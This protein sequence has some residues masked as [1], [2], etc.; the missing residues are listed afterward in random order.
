MKAFIFDPLWDDLISN[1]LLSKLKN[2]GIEITVTTEIAP[3]K[4]CKALFEGKENRILCIN[5]DYVNWKLPSED[6]QNIPN[7]K[8]ILGA[9]TSSSWIDSSYA[10]SKQIPICNIRNFSTEA[11]AE[12]SITMMFNVARQI[13]RLIKDGFPLDY[14]KDFMKYRGLELHHKTVG[15]IGLGNIGAAI[16]KKCEGLGMNVVYWSRSPKNTKYQRVELKE[17]FSTSDVIFPTIAINYETKKVVTTQLLKSMKPSAMLISV[18]HELFDQETVLNMVK[19]G[20][21][22][23]FGFESEPASFNKYQGNVWAA[24]AYAWVTNSSMNNSMTKWV[25]NMIHAKNNT[26]P[27]KITE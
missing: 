9:A 8:A 2:N 11:V 12:W 6:Y 23:G 17:L 22:F 16:A 19:D 3:L 24:P 18:V 1:E 26:F 5:P 7:L 15:I 27:N 13:P 21:L 14:G 10:N 4:K 20:K 25:E